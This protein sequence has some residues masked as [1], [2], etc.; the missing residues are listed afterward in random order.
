M[1]A[2]E[3][4]IMQ[5]PSQSGVRPLLKG[6]HTS[7]QGQLSATYKPKHLPEVFTADS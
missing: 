3:A 6:W 5:H 1:Q 2:A 4:I 7:A